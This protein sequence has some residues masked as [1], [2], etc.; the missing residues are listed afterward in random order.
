MLAR[1]T[2]SSCVRLSVRLSVRPSV[3]SQCFTKMAKP[4]ITQTTLS[5][6][7]RAI[8]SGNVCEENLVTFL[9]VVNEIMR[10]ARETNIQKTDRHAD[11]LLIAI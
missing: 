7:N 2:P 4:R 1:Y 3:T 5:E 6:G 11:T 9:R 10:A 8:A